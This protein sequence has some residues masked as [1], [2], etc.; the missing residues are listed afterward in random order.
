MD[1]ARSVP[2]L[3]HTD[4]TAIC[5]RI[6][7]NPG[8]LKILLKTK[9]DP[10]FIRRWV[11]HHAKIVGL[12]NLIIFDNMSDDPDILNFY[13]DLA[14]DLH[15]VRFAGFHDIVHHTSQI[16]ELYAALATACDYFIFLDTDEFLVLLDGQASSDGPGLLHFIE[17]N[18]DVD[19]FPATWLLN[20][21]GSETRFL[22]GPD[23]RSFS[24]GLAW[25]KPIIRSKARFSGFINHNIQIDKSLFRPRLVL[26]FFV[27]HMVQLS[28]AQRIKTNVIKLVARG[29]AAAQDSA[30]A[31]AE[32]DLADV[33][34]NSA[35]M[36]VTEIRRLLPAR[37]VP[38]VAVPALPQGCF[39]FMPGGAID[40]HSDAERTMMADYLA[41][42]GDVAARVLAIA[43]R[44]TY[45]EE[46]A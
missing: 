30:E 44:S 37:D 25:G 16:P 8:R 27:L 45:G 33:N 28:A 39:E 26:N 43:G 17:R 20:L 3:W 18:R 24:D 10:F 42:A 29:F 7:G 14:D 11:R 40:Y 19:V 22:C 41:N 9:N 2:L 31:I 13:A 21:A 46:T 4:K 38:I 12:R 6:A 32:R 1:R 34:D 5:A 36:Y 35:V 15:V 23:F